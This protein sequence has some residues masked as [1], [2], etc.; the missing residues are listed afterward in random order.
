VCP[1]RPSAVFHLSGEAVV[2]IRVLAVS[3]GRIPYQRENCGHDPS[4]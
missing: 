4:N 1:L 2:V 3:I